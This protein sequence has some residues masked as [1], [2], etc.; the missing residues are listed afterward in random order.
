[1]LVLCISSWSLLTFYFLYTKT[2]S[3]LFALQLNMQ[4]IK[5]VS[6]MTAGYFINIRHVS[7]SFNPAKFQLIC[8]FIAVLLFVQFGKDPLKIKATI[9]Q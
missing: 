6:L 7:K 2:L 4:L 3:L 8:E 5:K 9:D 1:M